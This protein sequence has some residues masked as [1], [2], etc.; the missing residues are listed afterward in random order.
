MHIYLF[1]THN[2][3]IQTEHSLRLHAIFTMIPSFVPAC[4]YIFGWMCMKMASITQYTHSGFLLEKT[5]N[6]AALFYGKIVD[7]KAI[8]FQM[9]CHILCGSC[10]GRYVC[11]MRSMPLFQCKTCSNILMH[12]THCSQWTQI[13]T[14]K[15]E[16][17]MKKSNF[18]LT[19]SSPVLTVSL[20]SFAVKCNR[21]KELVFFIHKLLGFE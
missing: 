19:M 6:A 20:Y 14:A 15:R 4:G 21:K 7:I 16:R 2:T 13:C 9:D 10:W 12:S 11:D 8:H 18:L 3:I 17:F 5:S 1:N